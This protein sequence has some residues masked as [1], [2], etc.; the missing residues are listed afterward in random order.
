MSRKEGLG[1]SPLRADRATDAAHQAPAG[2]GPDGSVSTGA[3]CVSDT[4]DPLAALGSKP[5]PKVTRL[6]QR[7]VNIARSMGRAFVVDQAKL[8]DFNRREASSKAREGG[9]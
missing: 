7:A 6:V 9:M 1:A 3:A 8:A 4:E 2:L 5:S